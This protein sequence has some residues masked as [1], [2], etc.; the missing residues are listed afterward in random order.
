MRTSA[1]ADRQKHAMQLTCYLPASVRSRINRKMKIPQIYVVVVVTERRRR[2]KK[3][4]LSAI[5]TAMDDTRLLL[6]LFFPL[7]FG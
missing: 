3:S 1:Q 6:L 7:Y 2:R 5:R 4:L